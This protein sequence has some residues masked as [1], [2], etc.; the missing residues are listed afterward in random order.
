[1]TSFHLPSRA[2]LE[3]DTMLQIVKKTRSFDDIGANY[4]SVVLLV[5]SIADSKW[6]RSLNLHQVIEFG[7]K[8]HLKHDLEKHSPF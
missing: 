1:M 5:I 3:E 2:S 7:T 8:T 6:S 4:P